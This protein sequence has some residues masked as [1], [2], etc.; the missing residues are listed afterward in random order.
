MGITLLL[1]WNFIK[2]SKAMKGIKDEKV[3]Q[4]AKEKG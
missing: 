3:F 4:H 1:S 2:N